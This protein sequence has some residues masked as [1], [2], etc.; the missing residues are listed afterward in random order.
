MITLNEEIQPDLVFLPSKDDTHQDHKVISDE[1]FRAFK[2]TSILGYE[3]PWNNLTF[4]TNAFC[5]LEK[6]HVDKKIESLREYI[7]QMNRSYINE[8]LILSLA[9]TRGGQIGHKYAETFEA[10][11]LIL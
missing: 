4:N 8:E 11:R 9:K 6:K 3:I 2:K 7:S 5:L 1:G 10:I